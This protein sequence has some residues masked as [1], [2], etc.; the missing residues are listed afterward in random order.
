MSSQE[1]K[2][3]A[4]VLESFGSP[5]TVKEVS[6]PTPGAGEALINLQTTALPYHTHLILNN[7]IPTGLVPPF[8][9]GF[10][11]VGVVRYLGPDA[12]RVNIGD[13]VYV[14]AT[15]QSRDDPVSPDTLIQGWISMSPGAAK[16]HARYHNGSFAK[17]ILVPLESVHR[18]P[19]SLVDKWGIQKLTWIQMLLPPYGQL[20]GGNLLPGGT[21]LIT[22]G[23]GFYS[24]LVV[25]IAL[26]IGAGKV[27]LAGRTQSKLDSISAKFNTPRVSTY[28]Y[29]G[30]VEADA[31]AIS[32]QYPNL[33]LAID[34]LPS[35]TND[36][37]TTLS[38]LFALRTGGTLVLGGGAAALNVPYG[39]VLYKR[40]TIKGQLMYEKQWIPELISI[41]DAGLI[42]LN[43]FEEQSFKLGKINEGVKAAQSFDGAFKMTTLDLKD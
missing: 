6:L 2:V 7:I 30:N 5:L 28:K 35:G 33:S 4:A 21:V 11:G 13:L 17:G 15:I 1:I 29:T 24:S 31:H 3:E 43:L 12:E 34:L 20:K 39:A 40:L 22:P 16:L 19:R 42:D 25:P 10:G 38:A 8:V 27:I 23:T 41:V 9:P 32:S 36:T 26:A 18:I 37:S 14:D